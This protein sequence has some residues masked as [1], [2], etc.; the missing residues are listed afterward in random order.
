MIVAGAGFDWFAMVV[1][2]KESFAQLFVE[3]NSFVPS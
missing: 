3:R 2:P 1:S